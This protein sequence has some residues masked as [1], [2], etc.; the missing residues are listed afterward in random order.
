M[1]SSRWAKRCAFQSLGHL[2][3]PP[4]PSNRL[5]VRP[6][7]CT[8]TTYA[9][10]VRCTLGSVEL[11]VSVQCPTSFSPLRTVLV[12]ELRAYAAEHLPRA[13]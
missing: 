3:D 13:R 1:V 10:V 4:P 2:Y 12:L 5:M 11:A 7:F 8:P 9:A 6:S